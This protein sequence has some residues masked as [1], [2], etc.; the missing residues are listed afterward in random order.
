LSI[1]D[2]ARSKKPN[3]ACAA[4]FAGTRRAGLSRMTAASCN[5]EHAPWR[6]ASAQRIPLSVLQHFFAWRRSRSSVFKR[7]SDMDRPPVGACML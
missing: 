4:R 1:L 2:A 6:S 3:H 7:T 5:D